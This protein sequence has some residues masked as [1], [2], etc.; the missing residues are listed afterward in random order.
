MLNY[1]CLS[2]TPVILSPVLQDLSELSFNEYQINIVASDK[3]SDNRS[4]PDFRDPKCLN[5]KYP[6]LLPTTSVI[7]VSPFDFFFVQ[8]K[9]IQISNNFFSSRLFIMRHGAC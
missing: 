3:V 4:L 1:L 5:I 6:K 8:L 7:M 2:G 9:R